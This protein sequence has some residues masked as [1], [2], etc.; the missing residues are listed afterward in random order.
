MTDN[1]KLSVKILLDREKL[2]AVR[3][4]L[5]RKNLKIEEEFEQY[6]EILFKKH[7]PKD[8]QIYIESMSPSAQKTKKK[9]SCKSE[10]PRENVSEA[11]RIPDQNSSAGASKNEPAD[12]PKSSEKEAPDV[13]TPPL[14]YDRFDQ[15]EKQT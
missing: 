10:N 12:S 13:Y 8:V 6:F 15:N 7:V 1:Q 4:F 9:M 14:P 5:A 11:G 3:A 2:T